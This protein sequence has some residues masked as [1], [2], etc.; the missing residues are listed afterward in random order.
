MTHEQASRMQYRY[1][2]Y[3]TVWLTGPNGEREEVA[4]TQRK[5]GSGLMQVARGER[6][7]ER[8]KQFQD[9]A[10]IT[11]KKRADRLEFSNGWRLE[12]GGTILQEAK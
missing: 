1:H 11:F 8:V 6:F 4:R 3:Y 12:F 10:E 2:S 9:A 7:Q 5:S